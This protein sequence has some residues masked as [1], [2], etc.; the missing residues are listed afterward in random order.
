LKIFDE[1][2]NLLDDLN[3]VLLDDLNLVKN[4][5]KA[6]CLIEK[7]KLQ[8]KKEPQRKIV[9]FSEYRDTVKYLKDILDR[10]FP[11]KVLSIVDNLSKKTIEEINKNFDAS[12][13][14]EKQEDK[15]KILLASDM[16]S[17]GFNLNRAGMVI[18][19]DIPWNPVRVIQ[20]VGRINRISKKVF[21]ELYIVNFF[22]TEKG[23]ELV[24]SREIAS[25]KMFLI[26][27][28]LGEDAKIF[29]IDEEPS[30][31]KLYEKIQQN[32]EEIEEESFY[33]KIYKEFNEIKKQYPELI[34]SLDNFPLRVKV[35]KKYL[36]DELFAFIKKGR[37]YIYSAKMDENLKYNY[38]PVTFEDVIDKVRC[39]YNESPVELSNNFWDLYEGIKNFKE[40]KSQMPLPENSIE[41][42][43]KNNLKTLIK[44][45]NDKISTYKNFLNMLLEDIVDYGTLP[46]YTLRRIT[47][48]ESES[49]D[50]IAKSIKE[51]EAL[52]KELGE[53]YL[54]KEKERQKNLK[55]EIIV[56]IE[57]Q[58]L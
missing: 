29:D 43:A 49:E 52:K 21:D 27:N 30:A 23:A 5:P 18:N 41:Q 7:L 31:S 42:K 56:A 1:I 47:N 28:T 54:D 36:E 25:N 55:K 17:E 38:S 44:L 9:I 22:P 51:I 19:Y 8:L 53:N 13:P 16:I 6:N 32:P 14:K 45:Q 15:Y 35:A 58:K 3:L 24:R 26:H 57:N 48:L 40:G 20:R 2:L 50:K 46:D 34:K 10:E 37:L 4:D 39:N 11:N 33:T 12:H